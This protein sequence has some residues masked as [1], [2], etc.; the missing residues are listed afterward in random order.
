MPWNMIDVVVY[1]PSVREL[2]TERYPNH[3]KGCPNYGK[4]PSCPPQAPL[5]MDICDSSRP[6][7]VIWNRFDFGAHVARMKAKH[8]EWSER[9][10]A[11]CLY[12]Q[13]TARKV[14]AG[15]IE[16]FKRTYPTYQVTRCP[17]AMG[18]NV[19]ATMKKYLA[20]SLEWPPV[21]HAYQVA[22]GFIWKKD[23]E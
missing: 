22:V 8:P 20:I 16:E 1:D 19:T 5:F 6:I 17:E 14:L 2:C 15:E 3:T 23:E 13:G 21:N 18:I 9:Q 11:C 12:W 4:K 10:L 7:F